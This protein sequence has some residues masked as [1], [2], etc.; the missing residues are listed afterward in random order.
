MH[1]QYASNFKFH[2]GK[3]YF[4]QRSAKDVLYIAHRTKKKKI[5]P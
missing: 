3:N 5:T 2:D 1:V 4:T